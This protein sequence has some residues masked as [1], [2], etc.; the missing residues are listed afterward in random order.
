MIL[1]VEV[2]VF[3]SDKS[4]KSQVQPSKRFSFRTVIS[5]LDVLWLFVAVCGFEFI[6]FVLVNH[7]LQVLDR[8]DVTYLIHELFVD[9]T[10]SKKNVRVSF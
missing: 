3:L 4:Q 8:F 6:I 9:V 5:L 7:Y 2:D 10:R 1:A